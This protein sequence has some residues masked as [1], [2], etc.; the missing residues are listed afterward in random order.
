MPKKNR[1][2][3]KRVKKVIV[4]DTETAPYYENVAPYWTY[5][6]ERPVYNVLPN[7]LQEIK[8]MVEVK[9]HDFTTDTDIIVKESQ[10]IKYKYQTDKRQRQLI[11]DIGWTVTDKHGNI[12]LKRNFLV[13]DIFTDMSLMRHAH[14]FSKYPLYITMLSKGEIELARWVKIVSAFEQ[15]ILDYDIHEAYAYNIAFDKLALE[16]TH[17]IITGRKFLFW[18]VHEMKTNC[19]WGMCAETIMQTKGFIK[20]AVEEGWLSPSGNITTNAE[21]AYRFITGMYDFEESHTAL[22]DAVIES[23]IM[24]RCFKTKR[25]I[26]FGILQQP[27]RLVKT[28]A[29]SLG[30]LPLEEEK[31]EK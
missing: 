6:K 21:T 23:E 20:T 27:W 7:T 25:K 17:R 4:F 24:A 28:K 31:E 8:G 9:R 2:Y 5:S 18:K 12:L 11:F 30:L 3:D 1:L 10:V 22:D 16:N 14:Y 26:S 29:E 13:E 15:D 19:L